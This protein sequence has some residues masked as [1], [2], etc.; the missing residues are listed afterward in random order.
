MIVEATVKRLRREH[1]ERMTQAWYTAAIPLMKKPPALK[2]LLV[3]EDAAPKRRKSAAELKAA[4]MF[5][6]G[7]PK[8]K[9]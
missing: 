3:P 5:A 1:N 4:L 6:L 7:A 8:P 2:D 9:A